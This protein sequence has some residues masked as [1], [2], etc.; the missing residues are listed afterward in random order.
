MVHDIDRLLQIWIG[1]FA[2]K[3]KDKPRLCN[4]RSNCNRERYCTGRKGKQG[5]WCSRT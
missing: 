3:Y 2:E 5:S 1:T 4:T